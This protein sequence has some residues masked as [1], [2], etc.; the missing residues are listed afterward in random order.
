[1]FAKVG[2]KYC[3][4]VNE[5]LKNPKDLK[6]HQSGKNLATSDHTVLRALFSHA[7]ANST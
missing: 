1:M 3:P 7:T 6:Y 5:H 4:K 2:P